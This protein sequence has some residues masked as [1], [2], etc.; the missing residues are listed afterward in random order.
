[1]TMKKKVRKDR[2]KERL[3]SREEFILKLRGLADALEA[4]ESFVIRVAGERLRVPRDAAVSIEHE[5][6]GAN[7]E[8]E[9]QVKWSKTRVR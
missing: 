2:D 9:F 6:S 7:E 3:L 5:R 8:V 1:M 4:E